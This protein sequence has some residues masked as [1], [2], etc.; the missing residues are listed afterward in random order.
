M[1]RQE[2]IGQIQLEY[3]DIKRVLD[4]KSLR[5]WCA[6]KSRAYNRIHKKGGVSIVS[7][8]TGIS[9]S[10]IQRGLKEME[11]A[12][13]EDSTKRVRKEGGGR[14]KNNG[15]TAKIRK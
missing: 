15:K 11:L 6:S 10:R 9:R 3:L 12:N 1:E 14:K 13:T 5:W 8:A 7:E 4:E 2:Q